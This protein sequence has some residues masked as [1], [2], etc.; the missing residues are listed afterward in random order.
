MH[1]ITYLA[2]IFLLL[3]GCSSSS[4]P[5]PATTTP[6]RTTDVL[7]DDSNGIESTPA[8]VVDDSS[9]AESIP[10]GFVNY[11]HPSGSF[12]I[13]YPS[14]W[15]LDS[16]SARSNLLALG[17]PDAVGN[18]VTGLRVSVPSLSPDGFDAM[19]YA[20]DIVDNM[21]Q[22]S[23]Q[24]LV[25]PVKSTEIQG[26]EAALVDFEIM[27]SATHGIRI[28]QLIVIE[29]GQFW[30]LICHTE[31]EQFAEYEANFHTIIESFKVLAEYHPDDVDIT[32]PV[33]P[34]PTNEEPA[35]VPPVPVPAI[36]QKPPILPK[37]KCEIDRDSIQI[38]LDAYYEANG[39]WPTEDG[40]TGDIVWE[41]LVPV[42]IEAIPAM[43][44]TCEWQVNSNP[45][46]KVCLLKPC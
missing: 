39:V 16:A 6:V 1:R 7:V 28:L 19:T 9:E 45:E 29:S 18:F 8:E 3:T 43:D 14:D 30:T 11:R 37:T 33:I 23:Q 24:L 46:G 26:H 25:Y 32:L 34:A 13:S 21:R 41:A 15:E 35:P 36:T 5:T 42:H 22:Q 38:A 44:N 2:I 31:T 20:E 40:G 12:S 27:N 10:D 4:T 17:L